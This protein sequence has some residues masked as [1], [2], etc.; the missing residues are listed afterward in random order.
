MWWGNQ[1][2]EHQYFGYCIK[3]K[4]TRILAI[5]TLVSKN[6]PQGYKEHVISFILFDFGEVVTIIDWLENM[7]IYVSCIVKSYKDTIIGRLGNSGTSDLLLHIVQW[8]GTCSVG[9]EKHDLPIFIYCSVMMYKY[10]SCLGFFPIKKMRKEK[11]FIMKYSTIY[12]ISSKNSSFKL[13]SR[14]FCYVQ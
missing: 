5:I 6:N 9:K 11:I 2:L 8:C 4:K 7:N 1:E 13:S 10:Y 14:L 3:S 12:H